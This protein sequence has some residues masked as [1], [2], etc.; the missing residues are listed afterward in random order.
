MGKLD[1]E[2]RI[3][4]LESRFEIAEL[5]GA[6]CTTV[7]A[8]DMA[9]MTALF[10]DDV[11]FE[12]SDGGMNSH[13]KDEVT[14]MFNKVFSI[15]GPGYHWTHNHSVTFDEGD[16]D[17]ATGLVLAHAE[18]TPNHTIS[19]AAFRYNDTYRREGGK[20][21]FA[22]RSLSFF[23]Y[24]PVTEFLDRF[25]QPERF[26]TPDGWRQAD[27]PESLDSWKEWQENN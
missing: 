18:T 13:G 7:D 1:M 8:R 15:R 26:K 6:Y 17:L 12:S 3:D 19:I 4:R 5:C 2:T 21:L 10:T 14:A 16:P 23:Y 25:K 22:K 27:F 24:M 11:V 9:G 20:W